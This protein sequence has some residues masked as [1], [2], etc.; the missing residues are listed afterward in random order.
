MLLR[1]S[2]VQTFH[3][4][5]VCLY[6]HTCV[7]VRVCVYVHICVSMY[8]YAC[9]CVIRIEFTEALCDGPS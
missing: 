1:Y 4:L 7:C 8:E 2:S 9:V 6:V 3:V 5:R